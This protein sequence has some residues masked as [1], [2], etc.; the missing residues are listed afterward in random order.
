MS[1]VRDVVE[2]GFGLIVGNWKYLYFK[3]SMK[4]FEVP[5]SKYY[6][7]GGFLANLRTTFYY[8]QI[9]AYFKCDTMRLNE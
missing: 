7:I 5:V 3:Q 2:W 6:T 9:N 4:I 8:N 1:K